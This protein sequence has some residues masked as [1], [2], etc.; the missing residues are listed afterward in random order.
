MENTIIVAAAADEAAPIKYMAPYAGCAMGEHFLYN[1]KRRAL[2]LRRPDQ[3]RLR[4]PADVAAAAP[5]AGP[6]GLPGRRLLPALAP[7]GAGRAA[8]RGARRRVADRAADHRD[9]GERRVGVHPDQRH[10]DHRRPD[11]PRGRS[12]LQ[13]DAPGDQ[14]R[15]LGLAGRRQRADE[16]HEEGGRE[17]ATRPLPVPRPRGVRAVRLRAR[18]R[19]PARAGPRRAA[20]RDAEPEG[21]QAAVGGR[22]GRLDLRG[23]RRLSGPHQDRARPGVPR[24]AAVG[25][26]LRAR[27]T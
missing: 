10:L 5:P 27:A 8:E 6:R 14:R 2:R 1:G 16:G 4:L 7:A 26:P 13:G 24:P 3:A 12:L 15:H 19:D 20:R 17:A 22:P 23:H 18:P 9:A 11:L 25:A 21:A